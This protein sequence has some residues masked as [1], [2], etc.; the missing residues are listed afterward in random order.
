LWFNVTARGFQ[1]NE[2][3]S[4]SARELEEKYLKPVKN[5]SQGACYRDGGK[6]VTFDIKDNKGDYIELRT[7]LCSWRTKILLIL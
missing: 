2:L 3:W 1:S 6:T 7:A 5:F 4:N